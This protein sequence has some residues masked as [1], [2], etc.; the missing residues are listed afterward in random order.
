MC[1]KVKNI[2]WERKRKRARAKE[3]KRWLGDKNKGDIRPKRSGKEQRKDVH[4]GGI[5]GFRKEKGDE[6]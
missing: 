2:N 1:G 3:E 4:K 5:W 6:F